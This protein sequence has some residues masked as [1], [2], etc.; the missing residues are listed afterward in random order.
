MCC[1]GLQAQFIISFGYLLDDFRYFLI[2]AYFSELLLQENG[3]RE[4]H[5][6]QLKLLKERQNAAPTNK[7]KNVF[8]T[9]PKTETEP[10]TSAFGFYPPNRLK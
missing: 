1:N 4:Y 2:P 3:K 5:T 7:Y 9:D 8:D 6:C 10:I